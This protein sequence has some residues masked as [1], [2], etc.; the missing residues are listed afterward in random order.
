MKVTGTATLESPRDQ[1]WEAL[2]DPAV[3]VRTIPGCQRLEAVGP[4]EYRVTVSAGVAAIKGV[5]DGEVRLSDQRPP[6]G[7]VLNAR[8][9]GAPGTVDATI[10]V[11]LA[12]DEENRTRLTYD[13]DAVVGGMLGGVGQRML[14]AVTKRTANEFFTNVDSALRAAATAAA[15]APELSG[16]GAAT[17]ALS[18]ASGAEARTGRQVAPGTVFTAPARER[19]ASPATAIIVAALVGALIALVGVWLGWL[20]AS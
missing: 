1:V 17:A 5:Y 19:A 10:V 18:V 13:A 14:T 11:S 6:D 4:D 9:A 3:L 2:T 16:T 15:E 7:F 20:L 8:G 12:T